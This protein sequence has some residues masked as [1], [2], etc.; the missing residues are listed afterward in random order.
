LPLTPEGE[1]KAVEVG[2]LLAGRKFALV[3]SSPMQRALETS[4][5]AGYAPEVTQDLCEWNYGAYEGRTT[6]EIQKLFYTY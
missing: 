4:R 3:L 1:R 5:L 2:R 6:A